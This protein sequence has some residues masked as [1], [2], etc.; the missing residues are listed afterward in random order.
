MFVTWLN[1]V[2]PTHDFL[3]GF[4]VEE[5]QNVRKPQIQIL[6]PPHLGHTQHHK[7]TN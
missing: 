7:P 3:A 2:K 1:L 5:K 6:P 4:I